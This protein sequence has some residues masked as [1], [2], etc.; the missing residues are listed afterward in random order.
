[1]ASQ[2]F[3]LI[4]SSLIEIIVNPG[5]E[6]PIDKLYSEE[7]A[8]RLTRYYL[9]MIGMLAL[10][11]ILSMIFLFPYEQ[12]NA[13]MVSQKDRRLLVNILIILEY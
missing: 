7:V 3:G 9:T 1:M 13:S 6:E 10:C 5:G 4:Y 12:D 2:G 11:C 8:N